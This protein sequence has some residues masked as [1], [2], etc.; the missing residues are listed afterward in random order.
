MARQIA[1]V[2][3]HA[4]HLDHAFLAAAIEKKVP[5][6]LYALALDSA[7]AELK[8]IRGGSFDRDL[9]AFRRFGPLG[10]GANIAP[11]LLDRRLIARR[12]GSPNSFRLQF[13]MALT[14][15]WAVRVS[16]T[17]RRR[18]RRSGA[19]LPGCESG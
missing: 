10:I 17:S 13:R 5:R 3:A 16:R 11:G 2:V 18:E 1:G 7:P 19:I 9:R 8:M 6:R 14:S 4:P 15:R 12:S